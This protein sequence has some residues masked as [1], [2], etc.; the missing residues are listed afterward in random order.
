MFTFS[1]FQQICINYQ[2]RRSIKFYALDH[3]HE[4]KERQETKNIVNHISEGVKCLRKNGEGLKEQ[5]GG[6]LEYTLWGKKADSLR[7]PDLTK[8]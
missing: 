6:N 1:L 5:D 2:G 4:Q 7:N 8:T 3:I